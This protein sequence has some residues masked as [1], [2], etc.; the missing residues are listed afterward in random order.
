MESIKKYKDIQKKLLSSFYWFWIK[1]WKFSVLVIFLVIWLWL[2]SMFT[3][4]KEYSPSIKLWMVNIRT[5]YLWASPEDIDDLITHKIEKEIKDI[6]WIR[7]INSTSRLWL[8]N[9]IVE[10][11]SDVDITK[12]L[13][14]VKDAV[15]KV[16]LPSEAEDP[17]VTDVTTDSKKIF[18]VL[19][20]SDSKKY[21][22]YFLMKKAENIKYNLEWNKIIDSVDIW[23]LPS[24]WKRESITTDDYFIIKVLLDKNKVEELKLSDIQIVNEIKNWNLNQPLWTHKV[25]KLKYEFRIQ[26]KIKSIQDLYNIPIKT[27]QG[28]TVFLKDISTIKE[29]CRDESEYFFIQNEKLLTWQRFVKLTF[30]KSKWINIFKANKYSQ[31]VLKKEISKMWYKWIHYEIINNSADDIYDDYNNLAWSALMTL[32][33]VF[34]ALLMFVWWKEASVATIA[35]PLAFFVSFF[36]L[37]QL[38]LSLNFLTNF[39]FIVTFGIAIDTTL[40]IVEWAHEKVKQ[41]FN[42]MNAILLAVRDYKLPVISWTA[43]T[44]VVFL[45]LL[46]LPW[47]VWKFLSF[48]PITIFSTLLASLFFSLTINSVLFYKFSKKN[49]FFKKDSVDLKFFSEEDKILLLEDRDWKS[50]NKDKK[51]K[52]FFAKIANYREKKIL[53]LTNSYIKLFKYFFSTKKSRMITVVVPFIV[54]VLS[55]VVLGKKIWFNM[56]PSE[57]KDIM[58]FSIEAKQW[59]DTEIMKKTFKN[60]LDFV[61]KIPE[62]K[63][64]YFSINWNKINWILELY[65]LSKRKKLWYRN[66]FDLQ[67]DFLWYLYKFEKKWY[68]ISTSTPKNWP[69]WDKSVWIKLHIDNIKNIDKLYDIAKNIENYLKTLKWTTN[70]EISSKLSPGQFQYFFNKNKLLS[71]WLTPKDFQYELYW[72]LNWVNSSSLKIHNDDIDIKVLYKDFD[73]WISPDELSN[74]NILTKKWVI[75]FWSVS[76][77]KFR[78]SIDQILREDTVITLSVWADLEKWVKSNEIQKKLNT[79]TKNLNLSDWIFF[80]LWWEKSDNADL[81]KSF[82]FAFIFSMFMMFAILVLQF[83]SFIQPIIILFSVLMGLFWV[84]IWLYLTWN[85]YWMMFWIWFIALT[86]I[87]VNDAIVLIDKANKNIEQWMKIEHAILNAWKTRLQPVILTTLTTVLWLI[88]LYSNVMFQPLA[89]TIMFWLTVAST[90]TLFIIPIMYYWVRKKTI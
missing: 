29:E 21:S 31:D 57:D 27:P 76:N 85:T 46:I 42:P 37:K 44:L 65:P 66:A 82:T 58:F 54:L 81:I 63:F 55:I 52:W 15:D 74:L 5:I 30:N 20:Y 24:F 75:K 70:V 41:W 88:S 71:I 68:K 25:W 35:I 56:F 17:L 8:S 36:V 38:W 7:K 1:Q 34:L 61:L 90:M 14:D 73:D 72:I 11:N 33:L 62:I 13:V 3:I 87:V 9:I 51:Y 67:K 47:S 86:W 18:D 49:N 23:W 28:W 10:F 22:K 6:D 48:I 84:N 83:N 12:A 32:V 39:S 50:Y 4:D 26:W 78:K 19:L 77:Y 43:T 16:D 45:P 59:T 80:S 60:K 64:T 69:P 40:V 89:V 53:K 2:F 79:Y